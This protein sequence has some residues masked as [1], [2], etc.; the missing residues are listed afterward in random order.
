[1]KTLFVRRSHVQSSLKGPTESDNQT[2]KTIKSMIV[3]VIAYVLL[4]SP[5]GISK[6]I[7]VIILVDMPPEVNLLSTILMYLASA[8]N[9][10]IYAIFRK[11]YRDA[12][13]RLVNLLL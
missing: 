2:N 10:F 11:D 3:V 9:P 5:Y 7:K 6:Q 12:F 8:V 1:M 4:Y 13:K